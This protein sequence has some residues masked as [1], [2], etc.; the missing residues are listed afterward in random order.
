MRRDR[1]GSAEHARPERGPGRD[2]DT[3][4]GWSAAGFWNEQEYLTMPGNRRVEL[5]NGKVE[6]LPPPTDVHHA[7]A[8][9][10]FASL[11]VFVSARGLG[12][13]RLAPLRLRLWPGTFRVPDVMFLAAGREHLR[14]VQYWG[15]ADLVMEVVSDEDRERDLVTKRE[16]YALA[17]IDEYWIIDTREQRVT[18][19]H[20]DGESYLEHGVFTRAEEATS[21]R[22]PGFAISVRHVFNAA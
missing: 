7:T 6:A 8:A 14:R 12:K 22:L 9:F 18:V 11:H 4:V 5:A 16:E 13:V 15:G 1:K 21:V 10:L 19:L 17:G 3:A 2:L 20:R